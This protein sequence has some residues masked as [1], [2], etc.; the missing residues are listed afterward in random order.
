ML[1]LLELCTV[2]ALLTLLSTDTPVVGKAGVEYHRSGGFAV[3]IQ[4]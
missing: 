2:L 1:A 3:E 4:V